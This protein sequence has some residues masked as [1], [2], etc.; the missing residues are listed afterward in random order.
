MGNDPPDGEVSR[1]FPQPGGTE[2]GGHG[3]QMPTGWEMGVTPH[4]G[5][6]G[7]GGAG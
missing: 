7:K 2:D 1:G 4:W 6:A 3:P 5:G